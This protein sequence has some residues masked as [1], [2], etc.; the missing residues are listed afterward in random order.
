MSAKRYGV[1][2]F[3]TGSLFLLPGLFLAALLLAL[4]ENPEQSSGLASTGQNIVLPIAASL[5]LLAAFII[6]LLAGGFWLFRNHYSQDAATTPPTAFDT[7]DPSFFGVFK[8]RVPCPDCERVK[9][10][11]I[12]YQDPI[13]G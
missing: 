6:L 10:V 1:V 5:L 3:P 4:F 2:Y 8:G 12:L 13:F 11:L 7:K 9:V